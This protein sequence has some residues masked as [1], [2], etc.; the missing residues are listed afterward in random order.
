MLRLRDPE[1]E[2]GRL[3]TK[4][5]REHAAGAYRYA[6]HLT[7][8]REDADDIVQTVFLALHQALLRG[9]KIMTPGAFLAT[10]VKRRAINLAARRRVEPDSDRVEDTAARNGDT[11]AVAELAR[12]QALLYT[13]PEPQHQAFVLRHWSG[14]SNREIAA[15]LATTEPAV[16]SLLVR[17]R[18]ALMAAAGSDRECA[19]V[20]AR[21]AHGGPI[22]AVD[23]DHISSCRGC[24]TAHQRLRRAADIAAAAALLPNLHVAHALAA[25][26]PG[27]STAAAVGASGAGASGGAVATAAG[28]KAGTAV[29]L[30]KAGA[31]LVAVT[32]VTAVGVHAHRWMRWTHST[33]QAHVAAAHTGRSPASTTPRG[34]AAT[35]APPGHAAAGGGP[36]PTHEAPHDIA[37]AKDGRDASSAGDT[38]STS[39]DGSPAG[40][41]DSSGGTSTA[42]GSGDTSAGGGDAGTGSGSDG[43]ASGSGSDG[44]ST[45]A[46]SGQPSGGSGGSS[47]NSGSSQGDSTGS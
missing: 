24:R 13:L 3:L 14:L 7:R 5:Y 32:A 21:L 37:P 33:P 45:D 43:S 1:R 10:A 12:I 35:A 26:A 22:P 8:S 18:G 41:G 4:I 15:V 46:S 27:F 16:E 25:A 29:L 11:D 36:S 39:G 2:A 38:G 42:G 9:E 20:C 34:A 47:D 23:A 28:S 40:S 44:G 30:A 17:A 19:D 6:Y 31:A